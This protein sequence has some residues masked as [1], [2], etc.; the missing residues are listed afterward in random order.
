MKLFH[1]FLDTKGNDIVQMRQGMEELKIVR[2]Q[3][4]YSMLID[5]Q[6]PEVSD[7]KVIK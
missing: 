5:I 4:G 7:L 3:M 6:L 2:A 1:D